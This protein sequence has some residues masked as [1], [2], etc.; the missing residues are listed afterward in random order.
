MKIII[1]ADGHNIRLWFPLSIIKSR[2]G[3]NVAKNS[4]E[5]NTSRYIAKHNQS[6]QDEEEQNLQAV[7]GSAKTQATVEQVTQEQEKDIS[8][9][10]EQMVEI[11]NTIKRYVKE[12]GH[13]NIIEVD[14][15]DGEKVIIRV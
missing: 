5:R 8:L 1:K 9:T 11:Y 6:T 12:N 7:E 15:H 4:I 3:Y 10:R 2:I 13:F 14:S